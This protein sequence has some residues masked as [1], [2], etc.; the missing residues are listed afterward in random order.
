MYSH[1]F[2][3]LLGFLLNIYADVKY[4]I[5]DMNLGAQLENL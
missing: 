2:K 4:E 3:L 5:R 1:V